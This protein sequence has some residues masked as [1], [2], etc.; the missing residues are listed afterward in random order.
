MTRRNALLTLALYVLL[1]LAV[2]APAV[3]APNTAALSWSAPSVYSDDTPIPPAVQA[4][5]TYGVY[6]GLQGAAKSKVATT[7]AGALTYSIG[8]GLL[9][10]KTYCWQLTT[11]DGTTESAGFSNEACKTFPA[12]TSPAPGALTVK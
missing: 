1:L 2:S 8:S 3:A 5:F 6:Q 10:G 12:A 11:I 4:T 7:A 9:S